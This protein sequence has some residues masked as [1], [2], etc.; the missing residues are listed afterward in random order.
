MRALLAEAGEH[1]RVRPAPREWSVFQ[2]VAHIV[3]AELV[4]SGRLRFILAQDEPPLPGYDQDLWIDKMHVSDDE[5]P[6]ALLAWFEP[7][8]AANLRLWHESTAQD[9]VRVGMHSE[10]GPESFELTFRLYAG[11][12]LVHMDQARQTLE[13]VRANS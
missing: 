8:R 10:R 12:D 5:S 3:D 11:H 9:R 2:C 13:Q 4:I 1:L 7:L 6:D